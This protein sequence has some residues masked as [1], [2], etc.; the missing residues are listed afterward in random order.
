[1]RGKDISRDDQSLEAPA[2]LL[3]MRSQQ[4]RTTL[5]GEAG[6]PTHLLNPYGSQ[7]S[8]NNPRGPQTVHYDPY[9]YGHNVN[10]KI[11]VSSD[12]RWDARPSTASLAPAL[13]SHWELPRI[14]PPTARLG[15]IER[16]RELKA[17]LQHSSK[18]L[19]RRMSKANVEDPRPR[20]VPPVPGIHT[21]QISDPTNAY[22]N[23]EPFHP[24]G[25]GFTDISLDGLA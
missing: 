13:A 23:A 15:G 4:S 7:H 2:H 5:R 24:D 21:R 20:N 10:L 22:K 3:G 25:N 14:P 16:I 19:L 17:A 8:L 9:R 6:P 1:M 18:D 11:P 12:S